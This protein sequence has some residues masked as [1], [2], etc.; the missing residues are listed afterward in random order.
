MF[1]WIMKKSLVT[2]PCLKI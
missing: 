1:P 2:S